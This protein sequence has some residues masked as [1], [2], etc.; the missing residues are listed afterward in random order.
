MWAAASPPLAAAE[1]HR[2]LEPGTAPVGPNVSVAAVRLPR[3][4]TLDVWAQVENPPGPHACVVGMEKGMSNDRCAQFGMSW[5]VVTLDPKFRDPTVRI[6]LWLTT[7][8]ID[9]RAWH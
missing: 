7:G 8:S 5:V 9:G 6:K 1:Y 2:R 3:Y 4:F